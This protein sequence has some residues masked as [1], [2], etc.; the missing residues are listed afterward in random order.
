MSSKAL[1]F[2]IDY[3]E[4]TT[5]LKGCANDVRNMAEFLTDK[6]GYETVDVFTEQDT[7]DQ[8][9]VYGILN[10]IWALVVQSHKDKLARVWLHFSG[11]GTGIVDT[12]G[13]EVDGQDEAI[14]PVDYATHGVITDD[15]L[16]SMLRQFPEETSV[17]CVFDCCHSG[18]LGDLRYR[19]SSPDSVDIDNQTSTCWGNVT[20]ISGCR[21]DQT[22]VDA[23][24]VC[25]KQEYSGAMTTCLLDCLRYRHKLQGTV[26][27]GRLLKD[28]RRLL[29]YY[30]FT[31]VPI[32]TSSR[33]LTADTILAM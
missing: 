21:D 23:Y 10:A 20:M 8:V 22:S 9:T 2:G 14:C 3:L 12:S 5:P 29:K 19:M 11:H 32:L 26:T 13:D 1:L 16:K 6:L 31:Q 30:Q 15:V 27:A 24:G 18:T 25:D 7:P 17:V 33:P 4:S 28:V